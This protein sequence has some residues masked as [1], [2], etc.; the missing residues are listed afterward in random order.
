MGVN[1]VS[2]TKVEERLRA[3]LARAPEGFLCSVEAM[4]AWTADPEPRVLDAGRWLSV[5]GVADDVEVVRPLGEVVFADTGKALAELLAV[6]GKDV[7]VYSLD[8]D[9][10]E[11]FEKRLLLPPEPN[12][13]LSAEDI[14]LLK[15]KSLRNAV[16]QAQRQGFAEAP[17]TAGDL[18]ACDELLSAWE[19]KGRDAG[20]H[21]RLLARLPAEGHYA[22]LFLQQARPAG[23]MVLALSPSKKQCSVLVSV[24]RPDA[25]SVSEY[26]LFCAAKWALERGAVELNY[27][28]S[29]P[30]RDPGLHSFK[31]KF[32]YLRAEIEYTIC[33]DA[34]VK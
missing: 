14:A 9:L 8:D 20:F 30:V 31:K 25:K 16:S 18:E 10:V 2:F 5:L 33:L 29:D 27:G 22:A 13:I 34:P 1:I 15:N 4:L 23:L 19:S 11:A 26:M 24:A 32:G 7:Y 21:R 17:V 3:L 28:S 6:H 12:Y